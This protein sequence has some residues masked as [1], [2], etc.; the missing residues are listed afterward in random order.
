MMGGLRERSDDELGRASR[1]ELQSALSWEWEEREQVGVRLHPVTLPCD[2]T[3]MKRTRTQMLTNVIELNEANA[4]LGKVNANQEHIIS[5]LNAQ[6]R[7]SDAN[8]VR[9]TSPLQSPRQTLTHR[10]RT[11]VEPAGGSCG[12]QGRS[13]RQAAGDHPRQGEGEE[14]A[15]QTIRRTGG[16]DSNVQWLTQLNNPPLTCTAG[17]EL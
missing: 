14:G 5:S 7:D 12:H 4:E 10:P 13:N 1:E 6:L 9:A 2:A 3:E 8:Q 17:K 15:G 16:P 11:P